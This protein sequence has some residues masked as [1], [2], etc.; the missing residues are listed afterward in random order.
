MRYHLG[1]ELGMLVMLGSRKRRGFTLIEIMLV[2]VIIGI[3]AAVIGPRLTGKTKGA[4][5][6]ATNR[7]ID[8][9]GTALGMFE[10]NAGRFPTTD[11]GLEAL[12]EKPSDLSDNEWEGPYLKEWPKDAFNQDFVY[13]SPGEINS[14]YDIIS[15]GPDKREG[16]ED[17]LTNAP[18]G[19]E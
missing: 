10:I 13:R 2:V 8:A 19:R 11:E 14:D 12:L 4:R 9:L 7:S 16:T 1:E 5:I 6:S 17:D 3:L 18:K 15:L